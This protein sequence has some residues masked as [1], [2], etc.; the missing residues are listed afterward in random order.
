MTK[1]R[2]IAIFLFFILLVPLRVFFHPGLPLTHD[3]EIQVA[4]IASFSQ[5]LAEGNIVPRWA[6]NLNWGYGTPLLMFV[7]PLPSYVASFF[8]FLGLSFIDSAKLVFILGFLF[9]GIFM[10]LWI[11]EIWGPAAG[12]VAGVLYTFAPYR[13]VD[14][15]VRG[16][17][18]ENFAFMWPPL[19]CWFI[20]RLSKD[21]R[22]IY[23][24]GGSLALAA[25]ILSHNMLS[26]MF[27]PV[28]LG[29]MGYLVFIAS[30]TNSFISRNKL[31]LVIRY[32]LLVILGFLLSAF[33]WLPAL[34]ES[35]YTLGEIV[36]RGNVSGFEN[37]GRLL[38]SPWNFGITGQFSVQLGILPWLVMALAPVLIWLFWRRKG[39]TWLWLTFLFFCFWSAIFL[40]LPAAKPLYQVIPLLAKFQFAWRFLSLA[41]FLAAIFG[42][43]LIYLLP[44]K[45]KFLCSVLLVVG[46]LLLTKDYWQAKDFFSKND[47]SYL[48]AYPGTTDTGEGSPLWSVRFMEHFPE[49]PVEVIE[50]KADIKEIA[51][52]TNLHR[53]Q[54]NAAKPTRLAENT[55]YFPG[56]QILVNGQPTAIQFQDPAWRG[57]MTFDLPAGEHKVEVIFK[58]TKM[59]LLADVVSGLGLA[60]LLFS[61][62]IIGKPWKN[63]KSRSL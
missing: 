22:W 58:E 62:I 6:G 28:I 15:Y 48:E 42:G 54:I 24:A 17:V 25:L 16:A 44:K 9:S 59:R 5:S 49:S 10:Y 43:A 40:I 37:F 38:Y 1:S 36:T 29:Y 4:R 12:L 21:S 39:K 27:L 45:L 14:L 3:G 63:R 57:V 7:Y 51:R 23:F 11:K 33:F 34:A 61:G 30:A 52:K 55:L 35:K 60:L 19:I 41:V 32:K 53:Y 8:H 18:G 46:C 50:G 56:W 2:V 47:I 20:L 26:L 31:L 13:F